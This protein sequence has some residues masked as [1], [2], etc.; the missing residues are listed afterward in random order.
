MGM[1]VGL[2]TSFLRAWAEQGD[3]KRTQTGR[4][5]SSKDVRPGGLA[6]DTLS[7]RPSRPLPHPYALN[8]QLGSQPSWGPT[9]HLPLQ[10]SGGWGRVMMAAWWMD[11]GFT[12]RGTVLLKK[13]LGIT[14]GHITTGGPRP[15]DPE[16]QAAPTIHRGPKVHWRHCRSS[17]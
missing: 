12:P 6:Q 9:W 7:A 14:R 4:L 15:R 13:S 5:I 3:R 1:G 2:G 8:L 10:L 11:S 16:W 17:K